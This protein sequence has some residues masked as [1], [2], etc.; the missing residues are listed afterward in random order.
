[1]LVCLIVALTSPVSANQ[2]G[3]MCVYGQQFSSGRAG[4]LLNN[5]S[6]K[7][8]FCA[9]CEFDNS[10]SGLLVKVSSGLIAFLSISVPAT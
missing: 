8:D 2:C 5:L 9:N 7:S 1:M 6:C 10:V 4:S 3:S